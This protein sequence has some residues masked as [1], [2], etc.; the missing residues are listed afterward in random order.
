MRS[1]DGDCAE[2]KQSGRL[3]LWG[4][5]RPS[6]VQDGCKDGQ[7]ETTEADCDVQGPHLS[8]GCDEICDLRWGEKYHPRPPAFVRSTPEGLL[9]LRSLTA[10]RRCFGTDN[11]SQ[12][13]KRNDQAGVEKMTTS[14]KWASKRPESSTLILEIKMWVGQLDPTKLL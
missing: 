5:L 12:V 6:L 7:R 2:T 13:E 10:K 9:W 14:Q 11:L 3:K 4:I 1:L 8:V